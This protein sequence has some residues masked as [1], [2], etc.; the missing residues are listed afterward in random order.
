MQQTSLFSI[1]RITYADV[2]GFHFPC[3]H[4]NYQE[5]ALQA[6]NL[7]IRSIEEPEVKAKKII[8][9]GTLIE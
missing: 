9:R 2:Y 8:V 6:I 7:A 1:D 4:H 3:I 5:I